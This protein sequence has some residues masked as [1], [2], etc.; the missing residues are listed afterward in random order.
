MI[1]EDL[2]R[3]GGLSAIG[4]VRVG[5]VQLVKVSMQFGLLLQY[6]VTISSLIISSLFLVMELDC[7][8]LGCRTEAFCT[9]VYRRAFKVL[10]LAIQNKL[11]HYLM[12]V[13]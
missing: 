1:C 10:R 9:A 8:A 11:F 6:S 2:A 12:S 4:S 13:K 3:L 5:R 7:C